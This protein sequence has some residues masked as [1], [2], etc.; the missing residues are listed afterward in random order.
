MPVDCS[1]LIVLFSFWAVL[2]LVEIDPYIPRSVFILLISFWAVLL[3]VKIDPYIPRSVYSI[4][5][6]CLDE[7]HSFVQ[8]D[9][10][11]SML[12]GVQRLFRSIEGG[13][14]RHKFKFD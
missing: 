9:Q 3:L 8:M 5:G 10:F 6:W 1:V 12:S 4:V 11:N 2:L 7:C 14:E 13:S